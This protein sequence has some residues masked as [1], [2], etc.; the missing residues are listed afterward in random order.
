[1]G[2]NPSSAPDCAESTLEEGSP[3]PPMDPWTALAMRVSK[4][5]TMVGLW[6]KIQQ[7]K[8]DMEECGRVWKMSP[9][10][11]VEWASKHENDA[12]ETLREFAGAILRGWG[13]SPAPQA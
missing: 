7:A 11:Q 8:Y 4:L 10:D 3:M 1:M 13:I 6:F 9:K 12:S 2:E 5:E